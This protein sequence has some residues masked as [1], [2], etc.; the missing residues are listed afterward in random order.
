MEEIVSYRHSLNGYKYGIQQAGTLLALS[1]L[2]E[3]ATV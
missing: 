2:S 3:E 1:L